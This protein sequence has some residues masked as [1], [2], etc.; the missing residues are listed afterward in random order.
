[1]IFCCDNFKNR[2]ENIGQRGFSY[3]LRKICGSLQFCLFVS[4]HDDPCTLE[5]KTRTK[6]T[7]NV[8]INYCPFC[9]KE[10]RLILESMMDDEINN[11]LKKSTPYISW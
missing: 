11:L 1:M 4:S 10:L 3:P 2:V 6:F 5:Q 9:G 7:A 8:G